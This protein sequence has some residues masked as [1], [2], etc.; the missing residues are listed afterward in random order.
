MAA[1]LLVAIAL[2]R[3][4]R[5]RLLVRAELMQFRL[6]V[7]IYQIQTSLRAFKPM[8]HSTLWTRKPFMR[9]QGRRVIPI[10][11]R[12]SKVTDL[13]EINNAMFYPVTIGLLGSKLS[14]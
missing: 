14:E 4:R 13:P 1:L 6:D 10:I 2:T 9:E 11:R 7:L 12:S 5:T 3:P 8:R